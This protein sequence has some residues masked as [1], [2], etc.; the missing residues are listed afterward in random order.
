[1]NMG[2][3]MS[4]HYAEVLLLAFSAN[5]STASGASW[6]GTQFSYRQ[7]ELTIAVIINKTL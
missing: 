2:M 7:E 5:V 3:E 1:M 4:F 6:Q